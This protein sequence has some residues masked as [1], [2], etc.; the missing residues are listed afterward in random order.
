MLKPHTDSE[1]EK[2]QLSVITPLIRY[3]GITRMLLRGYTL[4]TELRNHRLIRLTST[5]H[6][7]RT[8]CRTKYI[9]LNHM[10]NC[11]CVLSELILF[12]LTRR[13]SYTSTSVTFSTVLFFYGQHIMFSVVNYKVCSDNSTFFPGVHLLVYLCGNAIIYDEIFSMS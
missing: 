9:T 3:C 13:N 5:E 1:T 8:D 12:P 4:L 11:V 10:P 6:A 2:F 7:L